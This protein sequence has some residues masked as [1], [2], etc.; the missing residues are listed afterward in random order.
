MDRN[1]WNYMII[2]SLNLT[3]DQLL[4][5]FNPNLGV[6]LQDQLLLK[7]KLEFDNFGLFG[8]LWLLAFFLYINLIS[9]FENLHRSVHFGIFLIFDFQ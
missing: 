2:W 3:F 6:D 9:Q 1:L 5:I 4:F 7:Y 8:M